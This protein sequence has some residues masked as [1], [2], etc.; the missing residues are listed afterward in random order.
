VHAKKASL[1]DK[2]TY[3]RSPSDEYGEQ[4]SFSS[5]RLLI[6]PS[7]ALDSTGSPPGREFGRI[8]DLFAVGQIW[9]PFSGR[10]REFWRIFLLT[11]PGILANSTTL[12]RGNS[13]EFH[14]Q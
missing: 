10:G 3:R 12:L 2:T 5:R 7:H 6:Y 8:P 13:G 9:V 4:L 11:T 1:F 14:Y